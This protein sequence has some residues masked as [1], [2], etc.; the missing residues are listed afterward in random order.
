MAYRKGKVA[1]LPMDQRRVVNEMLRDGKPYAA[2]MAWVAS[3]AKIKLNDQNITNWKDG[4]HQDW[5][6]SQE[7]LE[8][9]ASKRE[10]ALELVKANE[11]SKIHEATLQI[12]ASQ[13]YDLLTDFDVSALK[14]LLAEKPGLYPKV[15]NGIAKL[16]KE[17]LGYE[18]FRGEVKRQL[19]DAKK[20]AAKG[21][22][23]PET[24]ERI[25]RELHLL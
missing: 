24:I 15:V 19:G 22:L 5:L 1:R 23:T 13:M 8:D 2:I 7:R 18:R 9:M 16:S 6:K 20:V 10:F 14:E 12:A 25:E 11:G 17:A 3:T 4:G 21:G